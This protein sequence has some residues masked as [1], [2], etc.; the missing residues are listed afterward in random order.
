MSATPKHSD[1]LRFDFDFPLK[2][3]CHPL[4]FNLE[5]ATNSPE[6]LL[7]AEESWGHF[8][9]R[10]MFPPLQL[11][12]GVLDAKRKKRFG[13][14]E[15]SGQ[16]NLIAQIADEHNFVVSN[17]DQG[18]SYGWFTAD[19]VSERAYFR[20]HF[21][22]AAFWM[23]AT[24]MHLTPIHGACVN[25][26]GRGVLL[27]GASGAGKSSLA[28]ACARSGW[29]FLSDDS[30]NLVRTSDDRTVIGNPYQIRFRPSAVDLFPELRAYR[31]M[32]RIT[33]KLSIELVTQAVPQI[34]T[35][36]ESS[37]DFVVFLNRCKGP[38]ELVPFARHKAFAYFEQQLCWGSDAVRSAQRASLKRLLGAEIF[39]MRY[40]DFDQAIAQLE[41]MVNTSG[42]EAV[43]APLSA[44]IDLNV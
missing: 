32:P 3:C 29:S 11:R 35:V 21:L 1:P 13:T 5:I 8:G 30:S 7:A 20:Y 14:P 25:L 17:T 6:V 31:V 43:T 23:M 41:M 15:I 24:P 18:I 39:E 40:Q 4:G 36:T 10:F 37:V 2:A 42:A 9:K 28:Y 16:W 34:K 22:E 27:C 38:A 26:G 44:E 33:G 12:F 19:L